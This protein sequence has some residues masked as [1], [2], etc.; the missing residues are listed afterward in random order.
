MWRL[1]KK[2]PDAGK[3]WRQE[4][5]RMTED[6]MIGWHHRLNERGFEQAPGVGDGQGGLVCCRPWVLRSMWLQRAGHKWVAELSWTYVE[7][8]KIENYCLGRTCVLSVTPVLGKQNSL[9]KRS[10]CSA[11]FKVTLAMW[12]PPMAL[13]VR[14]EPRLL[15]EGDPEWTT[16]K[17]KVIWAHPAQVCPRPCLPLSHEQKVAWCSGNVI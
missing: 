13:R 14:A 7:W 5:M 2:D 4:E 9:A 3:G 11:A 17:P 6:E 12:F 16:T 8:I 15:I 10:W 1:I